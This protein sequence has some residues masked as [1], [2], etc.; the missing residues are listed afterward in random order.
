LPRLKLPQPKK[1]LGSV[2]ALKLD[3]QQRRASNL[4]EIS[5]TAVYERR[6]GQRPVFVMGEFPLRRKPSRV[7][8]IHW[9]T[10]Q[11]VV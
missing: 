8:I 9:L 6:T 5:V 11:V 2:L 3:A 1:D 7:I 10:P 4:F